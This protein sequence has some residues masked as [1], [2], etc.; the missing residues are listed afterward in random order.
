M[1]QIQLDPEGEANAYDVRIFLFYSI[2]SLND[3]CAFLFYFQIL[4]LDDNATEKEISTAYRKL[5]KKWH[6]DKHHNPQSKNS[7]AAKFME[8]QKA[9]DT[10]SK[11]RRRQKYNKSDI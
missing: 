3:P 5:A 11:I 6:P 7:A 1:L 2:N 4:E 10:L 8:I 9:Y